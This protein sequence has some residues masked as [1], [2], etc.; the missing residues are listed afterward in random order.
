MKA[1]EYYEKTHGK[2]DGC[3][4]K[5][6]TDEAVEQYAK[7][8]VLKTLKNEIPKA[9]YYGVRNFPKYNSIPVSN[10]KNE[11]IERIGG[12]YFRTEV[13]PKYKLKE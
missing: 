13:E 10:S 5:F 12:R 7:E 8:I 2:L 4:I 3:S 6:W 9:Y 11:E 1:K